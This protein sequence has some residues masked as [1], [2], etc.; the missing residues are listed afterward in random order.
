MANS[1][2]LR[3]FTAPQTVLGLALLPALIYYGNPAVALLT[4]AFLSLTT[5]GQI[6]PHANAVGK[7]ALQSAI[8]LLGLKLNASQLMKISADYS[9]IV[10]GYVGLTLASGL[11]L[12]ML[13]RN[14]RVSSQLISLA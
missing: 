8:I 6:I 2:T 7:Y 14:N 12:G 13:L 11:C 4:G 9:V 1:V 3:T 10:T 5:N